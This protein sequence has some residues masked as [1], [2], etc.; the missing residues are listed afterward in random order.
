MWSD[1]M[2]MQ[3]WQNLTQSLVQVQ[4]QRIHTAGLLNQLDRIS[5]VQVFVGGDGYYRIKCSIDGQKQ[6]SERYSDAQRMLVRQGKD[7]KLVAAEIYED[8]LLNERGQA[9]QMKW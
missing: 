7:I 9:R 3:R 8:R 6:L 2:I 5:D 1:D 4:V